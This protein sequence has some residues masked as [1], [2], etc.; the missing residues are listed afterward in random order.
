[1]TRKRFTFLFIVGIFILLAIPWKTSR[2][3]VTLLYFRANPSTQDITLEWETGSETD[4]LGFIIWRGTDCSEASGA[5][6]VNEN[7][8]AATGDISTG[9][10]Y[11]FVD[12]GVEPD[13]LYDYR[14]EEVTIF[15]GSNC[16]YEFPL[17]AVLAGS[18]SSLSSPTPGSGENTPIPT[19]TSA[20]TN[21]P[22]P[23]DTPAPTNTPRPTDTPLPPGVPSLTPSATPEPT[24]TSV[25]TDTPVPTDA[26]AGET[27]VAATATPEI[28][29]TTDV[30]IT[31]NGEEDPPGLLGTPENNGETTIT[32]STVEEIAEDT[33]SEENNTDDGSQQ[34]I[35]GNDEIN[36]ETPEEDPATNEAQVEASGTNVFLYVLLAFGLL[37]V[38]GG[39]GVGAWL[40]IAKRSN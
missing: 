25:P 2:A 11:S 35:G 37:I 16:Q 1:M 13:I 22:A 8:I 15:G 33:S 30:F 26:P 21:T 14:L 3:N 36:N 31:G 23:T 12:V 34:T 39:L 28:K 27:P 32:E 38:V 5:E 4:S 6:Q 24:D 18:G 40:V 29:P 7:I 9:A 17:Q 10:T 20:P 19:S